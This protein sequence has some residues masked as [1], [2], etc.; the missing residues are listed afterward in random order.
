MKFL[1]AT[2]TLLAASAFLAAG[3]ILSG[4]AHANEAIEK[5]F[6]NY[7]GAGSAVISGT[8]RRETRDLDVTVERFKNVGFTLKWITVIR[9][10]NGGRTGADVKRREVEENFIPVEDKENVF[11]LSP[12]GVLFQ[13]SELPNPLRGDAV[14]WAA[15]EGDAMTVYS[16]AISETGGSELQVYRRSLTDKGMN[17]T[18]M[19]LQDEDVKVR[20]SGDLVR[21]K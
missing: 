16:L 21:T 20:M 13:K 19:R 4:A 6:G 12:E 9:D 18:F 8:D 1:H 15:I 5:F 11:I 3:S 7:V 10:E 14:R 17:I 2:R